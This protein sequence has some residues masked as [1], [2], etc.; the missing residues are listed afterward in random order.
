MNSAVNETREEESTGEVLEEKSEPLEV[1]VAQGLSEGFMQ[2]DTSK[3]VWQPKVA[4]ERL[5]PDNI[6]RGYLLQRVLLGHDSGNP[7]FAFLV[8][9]TKDCPCVDRYGKVAMAHTGQEVFIKEHYEFEP[10]TTW[11]DN[12]EQVVQVEVIPLGLRDFEDG[13]QIWTFNWGVGF[14]ASRMQVSPK[15]MARFAKK[16]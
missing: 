16:G 3:L 10:W 2:I 9:L 6:F 1:K 12:P 5:A 4:I 13:H 8:S 14:A 15:S 11:V 7:F